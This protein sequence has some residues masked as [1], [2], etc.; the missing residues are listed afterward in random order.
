VKRIARVFPRRTKAT[1][2]DE[3]AFVGEPGLFPPEVDEVHV[4]VAFTWDIAE[5]ERLAKAWRAIAPVKIGG[6]AFGEP[7]GDFVPGQYL[8]KGH[9]ITSRGCPN[10]CWFCRVWRANPKVIELPIREGWIVNDDNLLACSEAH[11]RAVF[12]MLSKQ[13]HAADFRGGL[14]AAR[15][16]AWHVELLARLARRPRVFFAYDTPDDLEPL[17]CAGRMLQEAGFSVRRR[18]AFCYVLMGYSGDSFDAAERR[19]RE[20]LAAGF[21]PFAMLYRDEDGACDREWR[22]FQRRWCRPAAIFGQS[23]KPAA[24]GRV[25]E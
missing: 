18:N 24:S 2:T 15:L 8:A 16:R 9:I 5:G 23:L 11:I 6:P 21:V 13:P 1:P 17:R 25:F 19:C 20:A 14:E 3:L 12:A 10:R 7:A 22:R 4:S